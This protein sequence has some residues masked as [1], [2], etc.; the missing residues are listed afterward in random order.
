MV[1]FDFQG[2]EEEE[3]EGKEEEEEEEPKEKKTPP[4]MVGEKVPYIRDRE[5]VYLYV[6]P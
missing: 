1:F 6:R 5:Y 3:E 4:K 2:L